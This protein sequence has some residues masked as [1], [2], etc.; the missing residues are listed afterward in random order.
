MAAWKRILGLPAALVLVAAMG[1]AGA[2][3]ALAQA[4][5][6]ATA[7]ALIDAENRADV[8]GA[9]ALFTP[10]AIVNDVRGVFIGTTQIRQW[11]RDLSTAHFVAV[12][13]PPVVAAERVTM[14]GTVAVDAL[15]GLGLSSLDATWE[16]IVQQGRVRT[17]AFAFTPASLARLQ[18]AQRQAQAAAAPAPAPAPSPGEPRT[19]ALTGAP[20]VAP[21]AAL[22]GGLV[23]AGLL[24]LAGGLR[25]SPGSTPSSTP[26]SSRRGIAAG[27]W[28]REK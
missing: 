23:V 2:G 15:R 10:D 3:P 22:A 1:A 4:D 16:L 21:L 6:A 14:S 28:G 9:V 7:V 24:L 13:G 27:G 26:R 5:A 8:E 19:L 25:Y 18:E 17:F 11:Q 20:P 12:I